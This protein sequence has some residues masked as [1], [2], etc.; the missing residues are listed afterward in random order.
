MN[1]LVATIA[2]YFEWQASKYGDLF[3]VSDN[4]YLEYIQLSPTKWD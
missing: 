3:E 4:I 1:L 2:V